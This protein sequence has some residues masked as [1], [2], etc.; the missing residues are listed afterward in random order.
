MISL[1]IFIYVYYLYKE[2][3]VGDS[4]FK[5]FYDGTKERKLAKLFIIAFFIRRFITVAVL[6]CLR[7]ISAIPRCGVFSAFQVI[8]L[9][10]LV[11]L[12]PFEIPKDNIIEILNE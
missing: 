5:E 9:I 6:V 8:N 1:P 7:S 3:K 10:Y 4:V 12:K 11:K 2:G